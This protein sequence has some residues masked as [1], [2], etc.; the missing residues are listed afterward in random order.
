M[1]IGDRFWSKVNKG[2]PDECWEWTAYRDG[3]G[4][5]RFGINNVVHRAHR[6]AWSLATGLDPD[7]LVICHRCDNPACVNPRHLFAGTH[8]DNVADKVA[9]GRELTKLTHEQVAEIRRRYVKGSRPERRRGTS[10]S[11]LA[12]E[13]DIT[14]EWVTR[15]CSKPS[16]VRA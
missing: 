8:A 3:A 7:G 10:S 6:I 13:F 1:R 5:G 12:A 16:G 15:L 4:Y 9:K 2:L 11:E 14:Q